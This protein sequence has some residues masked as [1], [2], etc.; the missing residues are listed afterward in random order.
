MIVLN[1]YA[2]KEQPFHRNLVNKMTVTTVKRFPATMQQF[3]LVGYEYKLKLASKKSSLY[4]RSIHEFLGKACK[5]YQLV[6][7]VCISTSKDPL[8]TQ[9]IRVSYDLQKKQ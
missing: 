2:I 6:Y 5:G 1:K 3:Y 7:I 9:L 4:G 8:A